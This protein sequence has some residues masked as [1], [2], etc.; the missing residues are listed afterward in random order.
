M[1]V[2]FVMDDLW[3][4]IVLTIEIGS[5]WRRNICA[6]KCANSQNRRTDG[7]GQRKRV[8]SSAYIHIPH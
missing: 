2:M 3:D 7:R 5:Q 6:R 8:V 1:F 4:M